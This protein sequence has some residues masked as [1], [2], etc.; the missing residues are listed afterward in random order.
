MKKGWGRLDFS[1]EVEIKTLRRL[2]DTLQL[3]IVTTIETRN[4]LH[5]S[6]EFELH[7]LSSKKPGLLEEVAAAQIQA[8]ATEIVQ[9]ESQAEK[10]DA[11]IS[12]LTGANE[13]PIK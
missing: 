3:Q 12:E 4:A 6:S 10:L 2:F 11:E 1:E 13:P 9:L 7:K 5:E 8:I